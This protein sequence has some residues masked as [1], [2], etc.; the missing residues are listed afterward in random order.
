MGYS[1]WGRTESDTTERL[2]RAQHSVTLKHWH[3]LGLT[4]TDALKGPSSLGY[5]CLPVSCVSFE[6]GEKRVI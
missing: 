2:S 5:W 1:L 6:C 3:K 4:G